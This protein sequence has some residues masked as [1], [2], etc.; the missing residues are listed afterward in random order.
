M[1]VLRYGQRELWVREL[2]PERDP[3]FMELC[4]LHADRMTAPVG[5]TRLDERPASPVPLQAT[6]LPEPPDRPAH[7]RGEPMGGADETV[8]APVPATRSA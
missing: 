8:A 2:P 4:E 6:S 1:V 5:W 3:N 7:P